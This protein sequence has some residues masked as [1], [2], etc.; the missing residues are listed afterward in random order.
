MRIMIDIGHPGHVHLFKNLA[1][2]MIKEGAKVLFTAR[3]KESELELL[4]TEGFDFVSFGKHYKQL[5]WK[6]WG[7]LKFD[8]KM[9]SNARRFKPDLLISHGSIY[10][11]H[12]AYL[13]GKKHLALEDSG[14]MEQ[15]N[16]YRPFT[17]VILTPQVLP[18]DLGPRQIRYDGYHEIAYLHPEYFTPDPAVFDWLGLEKGT[19]FAIVRFVS[20]TATH[21]VGQQGI[22]GEDKINLVKELSKKMKVFITSE[23]NLPEELK[24]FYLKLP[25]DKFHHALG[26]AD[27]VISEGSTT[28][29]EAAVLGIP[30]IYP[31]TN[32]GSNCLDLAKEGL[33]FHTTD[34]REAFKLLEEVSQ[35]DRQCFRERGRKL[36]RDKVDLTKYMHEL[37]KERYARS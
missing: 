26:F 17:D 6:M 25:F 20:W 12:A 28:A 3:E 36:L 23:V 16:L 34:S 11:A 14:N 18:N 13:L 22:S 35:T 2:L 4:Q 30:T 27:L 19:P 33:I 5:W 7:L 1:H 31:N 9:L 10:A 8:A 24:P 15:V 29:M 32:P 21:D 37:I